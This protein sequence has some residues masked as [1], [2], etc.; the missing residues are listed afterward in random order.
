MANARS[1][2]YPY[3]DLGEAISKIEIIYDREDRAPFTRE[4]AAK[5]CGYASYNGSAA[6]VMSALKKY[7][8]IEKTSSGFK[9]TADAIKIVVLK[10]SDQK[11]KRAKAIEHAAKSVDLFETLI[12]EIGTT[13]SEHNL[14]A[15][16]QI[17]GFTKDGAEKAAKTYLSTMELLE[18]NSKYLVSDVNSKETVSIKPKP[19]DLEIGDFIQWESNGSLQLPVSAKIR[20]ISEDKK[21]VFIEGSEV[22]IPTSE[23]ILENKGIEH[24]TKHTPTLPLPSDTFQKPMKTPEKGKSEF[25]VLVSGKVKNAYFEVRT[26]GPVDVKLID[27]IISY[28]QMAKQDYEDFD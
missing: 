28:L 4:V 12:E 3:I 6:K 2:Q 14:I 18:Q 17:R 19:L 10:N 22:G 11:D 20:A 8:L 7:G 15:Q 21:W 1:P 24:T 27:R 25:A 9:L 16:L 23:V 26:D 13:A 5:H